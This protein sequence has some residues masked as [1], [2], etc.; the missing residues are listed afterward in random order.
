M[1]PVPNTFLAILIASSV[2][3]FFSHLERFSAPLIIMLF[4][5]SPQSL[6]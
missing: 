6:T 5:L 2:F 1:T 4:F 3:Y